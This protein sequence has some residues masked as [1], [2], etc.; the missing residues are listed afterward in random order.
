MTQPADHSAQIEQLRQ[1]MISDP[2]CGTT[3]YNYAVALLA[4]NRFD[5]AEKELLETVK[6]SPTLSEAYVLL[7]GIAFQRNDLDTCL[8][9]NQMAVQ[10]RIGFAEGYGNI[11]FVQLQKG[12]VD[13][14]ITALE[15]AIAINPNFLQAYTNLGNAY[16][17]KGDIEKSIETNR[18]VLEIEPAFAVAHNNLA[19]AYLE[20]GETALAVEHCDKAEQMGYEVAPELKKEI[21]TYR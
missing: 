20:K 21:D 13:E 18:K 17:M 16:L 15:E 19:I 4:D 9:Y 12:N 8:K 7:G 1:E 2:T 6:S 5:E 14:A 3:R 11:G 10:A